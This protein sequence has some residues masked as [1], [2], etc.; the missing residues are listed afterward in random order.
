MMKKENLTCFIVGTVLKESGYW[1][2]VLLQVKKDRQ[3][4]PS[5][6]NIRALA[7]VARQRQ[8]WEK[9]TV[10]SWTKN[11]PERK[12][13]TSNLSGIPLK[14]IYDP[15]DVSY[16]DYSRDEGF[17]GEYPYT[18]GVYP[19]MY[20]GRLWTMRMF[21]GF[22]TPEDTNK[23]LHYLLE[24]GETGLS[25]AFDMP[26]LYG[27]DPDH[28]RAEGEVGRCRSEEHTSELQS[29]SNLVCRLLLEKKKQ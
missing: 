26:T 5:T 27:Y 4:R 16:R 24:H 23:R 1:R 15:K 21:S 25:I 13:E 7:K 18:R 19:T 17:P 20:R 12:L 2:K 22:G 6:Y 10:R 9:K 14:P 3:S 8:S 29:Q 11:R 28:P